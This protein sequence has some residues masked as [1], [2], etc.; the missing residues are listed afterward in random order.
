MNS[1]RRLTLSLIPRFIHLSAH[2]I[3]FGLILLALPTSY[4]TRQELRSPWAASPDVP[5]TSPGSPSAWY[6]PY[7]LSPAGL[8]T[9]DAHRTLLLMLPRSRDAGRS[10]FMLTPAHDAA[11][12]PAGPVP[13]F[14][15]RGHAA[16]GLPRVVPVLLG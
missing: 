4:H 11:G 8:L 16:P 13:R 3:G 5:S 6:D 9:P 7:V 14:L 2:R 15:A 10:G 1:A 12:G